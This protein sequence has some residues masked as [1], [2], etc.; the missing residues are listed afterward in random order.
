MPRRPFL[1]IALFAAGCPKPSGP[2]GHPVDTSGPVVATFGGHSMT[3]AELQKDFSEQ[4]TFVRSHYKSL[5]KKRE[6]LEVRIENDLL[7]DEGLKA[8]FDKDDEVEDDCKKAV[9]QQWIRAKFND[10]EGMRNISDAALHEYY[11]AHHELYQRP[12]RSRLQIVL[13][14]GDAKA[15]ADAEQALK[16]LASSKDVSA[17]ADLARIRSDDPASKIHGGDLDFRSHDDLAKSYGDEVAAAADA[18]KDPHDL[19]GVVHGKQGYYLLRLE[20]R[21]PPPPPK[22]RG[23]GAEHARPRVE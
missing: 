22:L 11:D 12:E 5:D 3:T 7:A 19:S 16:T 1:L 23:G 9:I 13:F 10:D 6:F 20:A 4:S 8:G 2:R 17:F 18:L 14:A 21:Q 15:K